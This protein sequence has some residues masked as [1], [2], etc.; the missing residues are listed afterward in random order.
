MTWCSPQPNKVCPAAIGEAPR[1]PAAEA[2]LVTCRSPSC[3]KTNQA[4][5]RISGLARGLGP[6]GPSQ[7]GPPLTFAVAGKLEAVF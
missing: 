4:E 1:P 6:R 5:T 2:D 3:L 7:G